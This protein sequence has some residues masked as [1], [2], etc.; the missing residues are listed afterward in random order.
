[1]ARLSGYGYFITDTGAQKIRSAAYRGEK[2]DI[3]QIQVGDGADNNLIWD[4]T[5]SELGNKV[6]QKDLDER[7]D[8]YTLDPNDP[9][10]LFISFTI[11]N[12]LEFDEINEVAFLDAD[13]SIIIYGFNAPVRKERGEEASQVLLQFDNYIRFEN[14]ELDYITINVLENGLHMLR[15]DF[16]E[17][18][19]NIHKYIFVYEAEC[20]DIDKLFGI[21]HEDPPEPP[22]VSDGCGCENLSEATDDEINSLFGEHTNPGGGEQEPGNQKPGT[23]PDPMDCDCEITEAT[24]ESIEKLFQKQE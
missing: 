24:E 14:Q 4:F 15:L 10:Q 1:M 7:T 6:Y 19:R 2:V 17:F 5:I 13:G 11:P 22:D 8:Y 23:K 12:D 9:K 21:E 20:A 3:S 18:K 16:E